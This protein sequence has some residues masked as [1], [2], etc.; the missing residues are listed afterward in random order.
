M[1]DSKSARQYQS[2]M[3]SILDKIDAMVDSVLYTNEENLVVLGNIERVIRTDLYQEIKSQGTVM[4]AILSKIGI[5]DKGITSVVNVDLSQL[6]FLVN[7][8]L[9][10]S[11]KQTS[12]LSKIGISDKEKSSN[13]SQNFDNNFFDKISTLFSNLKLKTTNSPPL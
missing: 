11:R 4:Q 2:A 13:N 1:A 3:T 12:L 6:E 7:E 5:S 10:E 9:I 8:Q